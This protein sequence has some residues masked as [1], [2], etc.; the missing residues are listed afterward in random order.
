VEQNAHRLGKNQILK[1]LCLKMLKEVGLTL[2][3]WDFGVLAPRAKRLI[4][5]FL[6]LNEKRC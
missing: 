3:K 5:E 4:L 1:N 2:L 6:A